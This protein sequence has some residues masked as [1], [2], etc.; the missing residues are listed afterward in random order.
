M[1]AVPAA[2]RWLIA[3]GAACAWLALLGALVPTVDALTS[4][5]PLFGALILLGAL[6]TA[7][8]LR[9]SIGWAAFG[10]VPVL[11][12]IAPEMVRAIPA[13]EPAAPQVRILTHNVWVANPRPADT[14]QALLSAG[15]DVMLLQEVSGRFR[16]MIDALRERYPYAT[17]CP[18]GCDLVILSRWPIRERD[19]F[20]HDREGRRT[21]PPI[22]WARIAPPDAAPFT[23]A[24]LHYP[25][26]LPATIQARKRADTALALAAADRTDLILA[27][28]MNLTPWSFAMR[29][30]D[31][32]FAPLIRFTR[33]LASW[34]RP[35]PLLPI[36]HL[37]AGPAWELVDARRV[38][39]S[40]SDHFPLLVTLGHR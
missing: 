15:A 16:P 32:A 9:W 6:L 35:L 38:P 19:Y 5:M 18:P 29:E 11:L 30:Q 25:H 10:L 17:D 23:V 40:G 1:S 37:Y 21:G 31:K 8:R 2:G 24:T 28:D 3:A 27:G 12:A 7:R 39:A 36:D 13:A 14:A 20:L 26:P 22:L 34:R 33:A 4:F